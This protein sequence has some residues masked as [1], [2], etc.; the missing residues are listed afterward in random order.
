MSAFPHC[1]VGSC[2][3]VKM[4]FVNTAEV[5]FG[6]D[7][8]SMLSV[9]RFFQKIGIKEE[10]VIGISEV[11]DS[12]SRV[13]RIKFTSGAI[14]DSFMEKHAGAF[15]YD[16]EGKEITVSVKDHNFK[17]TF[18]RIGDVPFEIH[19]DCVKTA[20]QQ[21]G[22]VLSIRRDKYKKGPE[23][24]YFECFN[25]W[26]TAKIA[27]S[28]EIPSYLKIGESQAF[29]KYPGQP[30]TCRACGVIGHKANACPAIKVAR[31]QHAAW[32][33]TISSVAGGAGTIIQ[34]HLVPLPKDK[35]HQNEANPIVVEGSSGA[36][37][38]QSGIG[39]EE[40]A[41]HQQVLADPQVTAAKTLVNL[42]ADGQPTTPVLN[43]G[44]PSTSSLSE[45]NPPPVEEE[46]KGQEEEQSKIEK[47][48]HE[49]EVM[50][51]GSEIEVAAEEQIIEERETADLTVS[52]YSASDFPPGPM[53]EEWQMKES[54]SAK[55]KRK[56][57]E[58]LVTT[59]KRASRSS[60]SSNRK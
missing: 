57:N 3:A 37:V 25:G 28:K 15:R 42:G 46:G 54:K 43:T 33:N 51:D 26:I 45:P 40:E 27:K 12:Q 6:R 11:R 8:V 55:H 1:H 19:L 21:F 22:T 60:S 52:Q 44:G 47:G 39:G 17:E 13:V 38:N 30:E 59:T 41:Q 58:D 18:V 34:P 7:Y 32:G 9:H 53:D 35:D 5:D 56:K 4:R 16:L 50:M 36:A 48:S 10:S 31:Q 49:N 23:N 29:V 2:P 24:G 20:L 14:F